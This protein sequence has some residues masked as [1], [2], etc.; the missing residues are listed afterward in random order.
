MFGG[1]SLAS[2][3]SAVSVGSNLL[4]AIKIGAVALAVLGVFG[5]THSGCQS[6]TNAG[7]KEAE[8]DR[9]E[10]LARRNAEANAKLRRDVAASRAAERGWRRTAGEAQA[11]A[12]AAIEARR[13]AGKRG[14]P[15]TPGCVY[16]PP[17]R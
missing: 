4:S 6:L 11:T 7:Y 8:A 15:C 1:G 13:E 14:E 5:F 10:D 12:A 17:P 16:S 2:A 3:I 9:L